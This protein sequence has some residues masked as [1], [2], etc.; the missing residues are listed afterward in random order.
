MANLCRLDARQLKFVG[1]QYTIV[2][3]LVGTKLI[4]NDCRDAGKL[5]NICTTLQHGTRDTIV[6]STRMRLRMRNSM[7][8]FIMMFDYVLVTLFKN[9]RYFNHK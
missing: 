8:S 6:M 7:E 4:Q 1:W 3:Q 2:G 9:G 5:N